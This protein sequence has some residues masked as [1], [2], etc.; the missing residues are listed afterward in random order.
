MNLPRVHRED[1]L[2]RAA[3][4]Q[5]A[6]S[7]TE[8]RRCVASRIALDQPECL[9]I[10][11]PRC[12]SRS[13]AWADKGCLII[14]IA[15]AL[16][17]SC[18]VG[19]DYHRPAAVATMPSAYAGATNEWKIA[20][21]MAHLPKGQWWKTFGDDELNRLEEQ[22]AAANQQIQA[23][24]AR[25]DRARAAADVARSGLFPRIGGGFAATRQR[26]S[27]SRPNNQ[28]GEAM[29]S[30]AAYDNLVLPFDFN[31]ELDLWGRVRRQLE[32]ARAAA[33][34]DAAD[35]ETVRLA[36]AAEVAADYFTIRA[37]DAEKEALLAS[38][39]AYRK[40][41]ELISN[42]RA[43]GLASDLDVAQ[44]ETVLNTAEAQLP[45][46]TLA[47]S[48]FE[49]ALAVLTGQ[50]AT[51]F[52]LPEAPFDREC[53]FVPA[54]V[55]SAL[56]ERRPDIA[57]AERR[58]ASANAAVGV[59][60]AA[61]F[62]T[63][64][65]NGQAGL[66]SVSADTL[67][68]WP[69]RYWGGGPSLTVPLFQGGRL[70]AN[71]RAARASYEVSLAQYRQTVLAAF[72]EVED[73]LAAQHLLESQYRKEM[74]ALASARKQLEIATNRYRSGLVSYLYVVAAQNAVLERERVAVRLR[75]QRFVA[76]VTLVKALGGGWEGF[77]PEH[78][79]R[80]AYASSTNSVLKPSRQQQ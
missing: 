67:F 2:R 13:E 72:A 56:L 30:S 52:Q 7:R 63:V 5:C 79:V 36:I 16:L 77:Q 68:D 25:F 8:G 29:G 47:R 76:A 51:L 62:P 64:Q 78:N 35:L 12:T 48:K 70:K 34:A 21:P 61:F 60:R 32:A 45:A 23:A 41:L 27:A 40:S 73:N 9:R 26:T 20:T 1:R 65:I 54:E 59:A 18:T 17:A 22:A 10:M 3:D 42:R 50:P 57:A 11:S 66:Q 71:A 6:V 4:L 74:E 38:I 37:L 33:Q 69:S 28:T 15:L 58:V 46:L 19:P 49:H 31:Y 80:P 39:E 43:G 24:L 14:F 75:G 55:P 44:A 53:P